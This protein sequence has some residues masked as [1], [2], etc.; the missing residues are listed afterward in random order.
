[1][2]GQHGGGGEAAQVVHPDARQAGLG[3]E[4]VQ[5]PQDVLGPQRL[6]ASPGENQILLLVGDAGG[7]PLQALPLGLAAQR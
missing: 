6:P 1:M 4:R 5:T 3:G 7:D 2:R